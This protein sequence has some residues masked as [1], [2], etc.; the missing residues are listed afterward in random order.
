M[1]LPATAEAGSEQR[2]ICF[3]AREIS[4]T[5]RRSRRRTLG[6]TIDARGLTVT[7]P[8]RVTLR[9]TEAFMRERGAWIVEK[10]DEWAARPA[11][12]VPQIHDGMQIPVL[13]EPCRVVWLAGAN[14][15]RWVEG[16]GGR[17]LHLHLRRQE[18][19][20]ALLLRSLQSYALQYF[21]GRVTEYGFLLARIASGIVVP[22]V[23]LT[24]ART[25]WGSCSR[26][27]GIRLNWR[28]IHLP[29]AQIDYVVAH[30]VAHLLEMNH[31]PRFWHV[32][33][34]LQPGFEVAKAHLRHA[35]RIIPVL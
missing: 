8:L 35:S 1:G 32:V 25:R 30:E 4:F 19:A 12:P 9:E 22:A 7:I 31:S 26:L 24:N 13:G 15:A 14:R 17:E 20:Q 3:G 33:E 18:D 28:L 10:L 16:M 27:T 2:S 6:M 21:T 34:Q 5:L 23:H 11:P 29:R